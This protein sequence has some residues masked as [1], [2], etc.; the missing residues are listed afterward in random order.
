MNHK[1]LFQATG[2]RTVKWAHP[3]PAL[4]PTSGP[5]PEHESAFQS[6]SDALVKKY[7]RIAHRAWSKKQERN[8]LRKTAY[9]VMQKAMRSGEFVCAKKLCSVCGSR[10]NLKAHHDDYAKP[11]CVRILCSSCHSKLHGIQ[12]RREV[13]ST[14]LLARAGSGAGAEDGCEVPALVGGI[15]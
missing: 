9:R 2:Q 12:I 14:R 8:R 15:A 11:L 1:T 7:E 3:A 4:L 13:F 5:S 6:R 10:K